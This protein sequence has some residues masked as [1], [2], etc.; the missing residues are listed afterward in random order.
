MEGPVVAHHMREFESGANRSE[1]AG[2]PDYEGY[3][4]P[5]VIERYGR[6]MLSH[7]DTPAG[8]RASDNWQLGIPQS[9]YLKSAQRHNL[10]LWLL[11]RGYRG[12]YTQDKEEALCGILF[13]AM[14][15]LH[16]I[17]NAKDALYAPL[18]K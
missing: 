2:K 5:L 9:E 17:L 3:L 7:Q 12:I 18:N 6:Y 11:H 13:N 1:V 4:S 15:Y 16:E 14:G 10:D 8:L